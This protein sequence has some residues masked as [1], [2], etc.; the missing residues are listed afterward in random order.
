MPPTTISKVFG[1]KI[2]KKKKE[3]KEKQVLDTYSCTQLVTVPYM[4][5]VQIQQLFE[6]MHA[7]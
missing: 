4:Y 5:L 3:R 2:L 7:S 1:S 6:S